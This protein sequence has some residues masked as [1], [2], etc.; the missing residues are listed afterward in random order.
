VGDDHPRFAAESESRR[1]A[2]LN[3]LLVASVLLAVGSV[4]YAVTTPAQ[5]ESFSAIY[6]VTENESSELVANDYPTE[7][8]SGASKSVVLGVDNNEYEAANYSIV[9][10]EQDVETRTTRRSFANSGNSSG[11]RPDS[12]TTRR[13]YTNTTSNRRLRAKKSESPGS[14]TS[15]ARFRT[16]HQPRT[17]TI[18]FTYWSPST[19]PVP[20]ERHRIHTYISTCH[21]SARSRFR[22]RTTSFDSPYDEV[23]LDMESCALGY[24][25][26]RIDALPSTDHPLAE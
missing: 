18:T 7:F 1:D 21:P 4:A 12:A 6:L 23:D 22:H 26:F 25:A 8:E 3:V 2:A 19:T 20:T 16:S 13:G 10:V 9:V 15:T 11:S 14:F 24:G 17:R 5:G